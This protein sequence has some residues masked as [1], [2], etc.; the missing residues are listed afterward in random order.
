MID[1]V[2]ALPILGIDCAK[3]DPYPNH[4]RAD[5]HNNHTIIFFMVV[6]ERCK[7]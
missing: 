3:T 5:I 2:I 6:I 7:K 1:V 4:R